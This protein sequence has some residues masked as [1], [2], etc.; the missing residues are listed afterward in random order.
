MNDNEDGLDIPEFLRVRPEDLEA[1]RKSWDEFWAKNPNRKQIK[2]TGYQRTETEKLYYASK[3]R[4]KAAYNARADVVANK[5]AYFAKKAEEA[6]AIKRVK[7]EAAAA[8]AAY[9]AENVTVV[10][11]VKKRGRPKGSKNKVK[12]V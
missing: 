5:E 7:E 4:D 12:N 11:T 9:K 8:H 6:A 3:E 1:R 2:N 10:T